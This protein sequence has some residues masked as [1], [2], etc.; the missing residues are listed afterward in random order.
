MGLIISPLVVPCVMMFATLVGLEIVKVPSVKPSVHV[1]LI[2]LKSVD[3]LA[4]LAEIPA[5]DSYCISFAM[6]G[7][8]DRLLTLE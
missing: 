3:T 7:S 1:A 6:I 2:S 5:V 4:M 8:T